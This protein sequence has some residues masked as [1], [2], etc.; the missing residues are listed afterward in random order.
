MTK[1]AS[2]KLYPLFYF[3]RWSIAHITRAV[4]TN[5]NQSIRSVFHSIYIALLS[6]LLIQKDNSRTFN[7]EAGC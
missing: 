5:P 4:V 2:L 3:D 7:H 1:P 6:P